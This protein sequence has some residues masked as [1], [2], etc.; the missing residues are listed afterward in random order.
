MHYLYT[1]IT[2]NNNPFLVRITVEEYGIDNAKRGYNVLRIKMSNL[3]SSQFTKLLRPLASSIPNNTDTGG[4]SDWTK[5]SIANLYSLVN[6]L[7]E[8]RGSSLSSPCLF[9][10]FRILKDDKRRRT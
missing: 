3:Q 2:I 9:F 8:Y 4:S 10:C 6:A 1:P 5:M 7:V